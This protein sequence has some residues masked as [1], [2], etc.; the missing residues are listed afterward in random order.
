LEQRAALVDEPVLQGV[1]R[2]RWQYR[3]ALLDRQ[4]R[5]QP[6]DTVDPHADADRSVRRPRFEPVHVQRLLRRREAQFDLPPG[7]D[8][9]RRRR[10]VHR[11][12]PR[13]V[14]ETAAQF[15]ARAPVRVGPAAH[16]VERAELGDQAVHGEQHDLGAL[17]RSAV[18]AD[19]LDRERVHLPRQD[20]AR[21]LGHDGR[22]P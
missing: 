6:G 7:F 22:R 1:A 4:V 20:R 15:D 21:L 8:G 11:R 19:H 5:A 13:A 10:G 9:N 3:V 12:R 16:D 2:Q 18:G 14:L 17:D